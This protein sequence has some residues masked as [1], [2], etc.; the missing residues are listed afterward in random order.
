MFCTIFKIKF[1]QIDL[2]RIFWIIMQIKSNKL[3]R[4]EASEYSFRKI[5]SIDRMFWIIVRIK[6][7]HIGLGRILWIILQV[8]S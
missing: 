5:I 6:S 4:I 8:K 2:N 3:M 7:K 1:H